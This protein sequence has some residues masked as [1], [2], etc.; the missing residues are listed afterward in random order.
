MSKRQMT[1][2][3]RALLVLVLT[4]ATREW[5]L[6]HDPK[7]LAQAVGA[8]LYGNETPGID[9]DHLRVLVEVD[10]IL[11][12]RGIRHTKMASRKKYGYTCPHCGNH[13]RK[14]IEENGSDTVLCVARVAPG[15]DAF[16]EV[17]EPDD[18][19]KVVCGMQWT[20]GEWMDEG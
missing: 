18:D 15:E 6:T 8:L 1:Q 7:A 19:G 12:A 9:P 10:D 5:L 20:P 16:T 3:T 11:I 4:K 2:T 13:D 14:L 17:T